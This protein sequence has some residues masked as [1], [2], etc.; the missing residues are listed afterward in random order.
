[1]GGIDAAR[2]KYSQK[3]QK[4]PLLEGFLFIPVF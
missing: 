4:N 3:A 1:M 2:R